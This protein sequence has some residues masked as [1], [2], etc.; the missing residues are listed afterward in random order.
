M[1]TYRFETTWRLEAP[2]EQV[3]AALEDAEGY[4]RWWRGIERVE[5]LAPGT[6]E[7]VGRHVRITLRS[8]LPYALRFE[9]IGRA[10]HYPAQIV[11]AAVG[12]LHGS[13]RWDLRQDGNV[14]TAT[15]TWEVDTTK[16]WMR[17][18]EPLVRPAFVWNHHAVMRV[19]ARGLAAHLGVRLVDQ[20]SA[21][22]VRLTDGAAAAGVVAG[23]AGLAGAVARRQRARRGRPPNR[24]SRSAAH[25]YRAR[26]HRRR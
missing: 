17:I 24:R 6:P 26:A 1:G 14:T 23:A 16:A 7:G 9:T 18:V 15:Y 2:R 8:R 12:D 4:A 5:V 22:A 25:R 13:G 20:H 21:P 11:V 10:V 19:G 3:W